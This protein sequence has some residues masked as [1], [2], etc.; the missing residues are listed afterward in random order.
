MP[1]PR[2]LPDTVNLFNYVGEVNDIATYQK[3]I[4]RKCYCVIRDSSSA[5]RN[6]NGTVPN[7]RSTLYIFDRCSIVTDD[8]GNTLTYIPYE[9][10]D[11]LANKSGYWTL[12]DGPTR[13]YFIKVGKS[14]EPRENPVIGFSHLTG[15]TPRMQHFKVEGA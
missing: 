9:D 7:T 8:S 6:G 15:G 12:R 3:A 11:T 4:I 10:F 5:D 13:D 2:M 1:S 14:A